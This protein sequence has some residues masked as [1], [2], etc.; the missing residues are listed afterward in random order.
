[1]ERKYKDTLIL[2]IRQWL[3]PKS[4]RWGAMSSLHAN[5]TRSDCWDKKGKKTSTIDGNFSIRD[6]NDCISLDID[7][8]KSHKN[9]VSQLTA[10]YRFRIY[11]D[12]YITA[13]EKLAREI[14]DEGCW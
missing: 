14:R 3:R 5:L 9:A 6:C 12:R 4:A 10:L 8:T 11:L 7:A 1:M 13:V 2:D